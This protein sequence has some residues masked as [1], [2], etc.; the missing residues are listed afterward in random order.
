[1]QTTE[2]KRASLHDT[3][4]LAAMA[5]EIWQ[6]HFTPI[7]GADQVRYMLD[8]F[9]SSTAMAHQMQHE[10]YQYYFLVYNGLRAGYCAIR[11][12]PEALFLSKLYVKQPFRGRRIARAAIDFMAGYC[13]REGK[14]KIWLT[15]NRHNDDTIAAYRKMGFVTVREQAADIGGGYVMDDYIMEKP[16]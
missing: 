5:K 6:Q 3:D 2:L 10:D 9:Q 11:P 14:K 16:L 13:R 15:V 7:I 12:E 8:R 1:M 4:E